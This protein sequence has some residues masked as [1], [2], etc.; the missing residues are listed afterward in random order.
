[1]V[2][3][4]FAFFPDERNHIFESITNQELSFAGPYPVA[5]GCQGQVSKNA[6]KCVLE[7]LP[8]SDLQMH[9]PYFACDLELLISEKDI[10]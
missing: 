1:M 6:M 4:C 3:I 8:K 9:Y 5:V 2:L 7:E 10:W